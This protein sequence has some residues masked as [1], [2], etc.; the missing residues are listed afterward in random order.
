MAD[1]DLARL[2]IAALGEH[3]SGRRASTDPLDLLGE[4]W[5]WPTHVGAFPTDWGLTPSHPDHAFAS[6]Q[7]G[8]DA[9]CGADARY[10]GFRGS[11]GEPAAC[12]RWVLSSRPSCGAFPSH[13]TTKLVNLLSRLD[14]LEDTHVCDV[15]KFRGPGPD[16]LADEGLTEEMWRV[17]LDLL[18]QEFA[19]TNPEVVLVAGRRS[20]QWVRGMLASRSNGPHGAFLAALES[21]V[22][23]VTSWM[24][25]VPTEDLVRQWTEATGRSAPTQSEAATPRR[26]VTTCCPTLTI[27][28]RVKLKPFV[29]EVVDLVETILCD[30]GQCFGIRAH[31]SQVSFWVDGR[32][33]VCVK[34][35]DGALNPRFANRDARALAQG[36]LEKLGMKVRH[37]RAAHGVPRLLFVV[38]QH[39]W[40]E[41]VCMV[42]VRSAI[43]GWVEV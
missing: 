8:K 1:G 2:F 15:I 40:T 9:A 36:R 21:R 11:V 17:S 12:R 38:P 30:A 4:P 13:T 29:R 25:Y 37:D 19:L 34:T 22:R 31:N 26:G 14:W 7:G 18:A 42:E 10:R 43:L 32:M 3:F 33:V 23:F 5:W 24:A 28:E 41:E 27:A 6:L 39:R 16:A 35:Q 20:Q